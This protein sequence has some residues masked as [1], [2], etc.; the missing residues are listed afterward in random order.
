[1]TPAEFFR[2]FS[3]TLQANVDIVFLLGY[4]RFLGAFTKLR[5]ATISFV[6]SACSPVRV[7]QIGNRWRDFHEILYL[8]F[9]K[10]VEKSQDS[11]NSDENN[12]Y[13]TFVKTYVHLS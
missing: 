9:R 8:N 2:E 3:H 12:G 1:V 7:E 6:M 13:F 5:K 4:E 11:S 10:S